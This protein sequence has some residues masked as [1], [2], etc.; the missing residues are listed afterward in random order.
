MIYIQKKSQ[1]TVDPISRIDH[2][3]TF[4]TK[5]KW[6]LKILVE[7]DNKKKGF[8]NVGNGKERAQGKFQQVSCKVGKHKFQSKCEMNLSTKIRTCNL[9]EMF[10]EKNPC[11]IFVLIVPERNDTFLQ[12]LCLFHHCWPYPKQV[13]EVKFAVYSK[14]Y[15]LGPWILIK[16]DDFGIHDAKSHSTND[17]KNQSLDTQN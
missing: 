17:Y 5:S 3:R 15:L 2:A 13:L 16:H 12:V 1:K 10:G 14:N 8:G 7:S 11:G 6:F 9:V 4:G